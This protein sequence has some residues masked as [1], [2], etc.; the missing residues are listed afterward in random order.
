[1]GRTV[2]GVAQF[3][4]LGAG[5]FDAAQGLQAKLYILY[6]ECGRTKRGAK[7]PSLQRLLS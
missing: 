1:M 2:H 3:M 5:S 7:I 6:C 4:P